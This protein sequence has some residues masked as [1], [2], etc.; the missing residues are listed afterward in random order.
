[1]AADAGNSYAMYN[2]GT[3]ARQSRF[4]DDGVVK[5]DPGA[6]LMWLTRSFDAGRISAAFKI[7]VVHRELG[8][9]LEAMG[10]LQVYSYYLKGGANPRPEKELGWLRRGP[11]ADLMAKLQVD[12]K[13]TGEAD[14]RARTVA[15]LE[16]HGTR[17]EAAPR[18]PYPPIDDCGVKRPPKGFRA[19]V[20]HPVQ[21]SMVEIVAVV[22]PDGSARE[23]FVLDSTPDAMT[24]SFMRQSGFSVFCPKSEETADRHVFLNWNFVNSFNANRM[25]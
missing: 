21:S 9:P 18:T 20:V 12:L 2:L 13:G 23:V 7:A 3:L 8:D 22:E 17:F 24:V 25:R 4:K 11:V 10:W 5:Y 1:M 6:A 15:L 14:I 16:Y 19:S